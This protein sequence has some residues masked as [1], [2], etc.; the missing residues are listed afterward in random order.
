VAGGAL[1]GA[2][3]GAAVSNPWHTGEGALLG[4]FAGAAVGGIA[5]AQRSNEI[6]RAQAQASVDAIRSQAAALERQAVQ[7]RR[8]LSACLEG[9]GYSVQ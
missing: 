1:T 6:N 8:A 9:R 5:D 7:F 2:V 3:V 4:A